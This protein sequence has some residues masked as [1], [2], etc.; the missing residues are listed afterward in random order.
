[1]TSNEVTTRSFA[2]KIYLDMDDCLVGFSK[3]L[4]TFN[5]KNE[6]TFIHKPRSEWTELQIRLDKA[7]CDCMN[8]EGFFRSLPMM[9]GADKLWAMSGKPYVLTA[10]PTTARDRDMIGREKREWIEEYFG[11]IPDD[12]FIYCSREDKAKYAE[13]LIE[14]TKYGTV[15]HPNIL[16]DDMESNCQ[17]WA[18]AGGEAIIFKDMNKAINDL[19]H[20]LHKESVHFDVV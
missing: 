12:R 15:Y 4:E 3:G 8:T 7:V 14:S 10:W 1:M 20:L 17:A 18:D 13:E 9:P 19:Q 11:V 6:T 2:P 5:L 16:I